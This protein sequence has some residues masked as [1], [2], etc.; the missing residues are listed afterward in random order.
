LINFVLHLVNIGLVYA[1]GLLLLRKLAPGETWPA[2]A[3]AG[4]WALHPVLTE[5]VTN[6]IGRCDLL[7]AF[8]VLAGLLCHIHAASAGGWR[9][10]LWLAGLTLAV[11]IGIF[12]KESA[13]VVI[14]V[15]LVYDIAFASTSWGERA[16]GYVA[17][18]VPLAIYFF[19][20][21]QVLANLPTVHVAFGDNP[22]VGSDFWTSRLT[23]V[24]VIGK[25]IGR[26]LWPQTLS[27]DYSYNQIP[28]FG[29]HSGTWED[30]KAL[31]AVAVCVGALLL[32]LYF[33]RISRPVFFFLL[34]FFITLAPTA[35][36]FMI[37]GTIMA[38]RFLYLPGIA[39]AGLLVIA[40]SAVSRRLPPASAA[41][42]YAGPVFLA[43]VALA[44]AAR[45]YARNFDW[46]NG[47]TLWSSAARLSPASFKAHTAYA[48]AL[49]DG[50]PAG[51]D[52]AIEEMDRALAILGTLPD[53][54]NVAI[55]YTNAGS[56]Y[57]Q[58]GDLVAIKNPDGTYTATPASLPWYR[59]A[60]D[61]L[62]IGQRIERAANA[63]ARREDLA[64]G[65]DKLFDYSLYQL[66]AELGHV[67]VRLG[68]YP[69]AL[70]AFERGRSRKTDPQFFVDIA[71][72][73]RAAGE[74]RKAAVTLL[75][76]LIV[77]TTYTRFATGLVQIYKQIDPQGCAVRG[78]GSAVNLNL[79]CPMVHQ[80]VCTASGNVARAYRKANQ[81][82][83]AQRTVQIAVG[84]LGCP[85]QMFQ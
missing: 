20:R 77:D 80:D 55:T 81:F 10:P 79:E 72:V 49:N 7:A 9:K 75:E 16:P 50:T 17:M 6:I 43:V 30:A 68:D 52:R 58:K 59:K 29:W 70:Q 60:L 14:A 3:F 62:L 35:N 53:E 5:S 47:K 34:L 78:T 21:A 66:D 54:K 24:K 1:L 73:W 2:I 61:T 4:V 46:Q 57:R 23:A 40:V 67:Y 69:H 64:A 18:A 71:G 41:A 74:P 56:Y 15:M 83:A 85:A 26:L 31:V 13:V 33:Y 25:Y 45:T 82:P 8:G 19:I 32:A 63:A 44:F 36:V 51:L 27:P 11:A 76:G 37:I 28:L 42:R 65:K 38:E 84:Q 22:L 39:F 48:E 12:S